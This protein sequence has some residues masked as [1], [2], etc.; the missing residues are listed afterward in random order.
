MKVGFSASGYRRWFYPLSASILALFTVVSFIWSQFYPY[1]MQVYGL[2]EVAPIA[3]SASLMGVALLLFQIPAG[4]AVDRVGPKIPMA[5]SGLVFL[6][7]ALVVS[8]MF[9]IYFWEDAKTYW[10]IGSFLIGA[11]V[12]LFVGT[13]PGLVGKWFVDRPGRAF[14]VTIAGQNL[15]P[16]LLAPLVAYIILSRSA[17]DA[18]LLTL[19][20]VA[21]STLPQQL[22]TLLLYY[23]LRRGMADA[24]VALGIIVLIL[25]YGVGV[26]LWRNPPE[27]WTPSELN[28]AGER[29]AVAVAEVALRDAVRDKRFWILFAI[30]VATAIGWFLFILNVATIIVEGLTR[31]VGI[32][33]SLVSYMRYFTTNELVILANYVVSYTSNTVVP[34]FMSITAVAN[35]LGALTW[36]SLNDRIGGPLRTLPIVYTLAGVACMAFYLGY[37]NLALLFVLGVVVYF[38]LGGEPTVHFA[39]VPA[40]FGGK[41]AGRI[42]VILNSSIALS[43]VIG[44]YIG[45]FIRDVTGTYFGSI[46]LFT[47]LHLA[48]TLI[49]VLGTRKLL[50]SGG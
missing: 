48:S 31:S 45:A 38:A 8:R 27:G 49:V 46:L 33:A 32:D 19:S 25:A 1:M 20:V 26:A 2:S 34:F 6:A 5:A 28:N 37:T 47:V 43:S 40:F 15:S 12:A 7:G 16:A 41:A 42:T 22:L 44:P 18:P 17:S 21:S 35:A 9:T 23:P 13:F 3:L 24:F 14:G 4:F 36:G 11:G 50:K 30:M 39:A 29:S 10:Y